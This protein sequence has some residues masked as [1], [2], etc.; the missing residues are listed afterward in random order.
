MFTKIKQRIERNLIDEI[1]NLS[2][3]DLEKVGTHMLSV[4]ENIEMLNHGIN[5]E[6]RPC[7]YT[8]DS[9][10]QD[11]SIVGEYSVERDYFTDFSEDEEGG[12]YKKIHKDIM[13][14]L[15]HGGENLQKIYLI[16]SQEEIPSFR[17]KFNKTKDFIENSDTVNIID[18]RLMAQEIYK[19]TIDSADNMSFYKGYFP[20]FIQ[21]CENYEYYGKIPAPCDN[22]CRD[23]A[24]L[25][26][27]D[28]HF[29]KKHSLCLLYGVSGSGK[30]QSVIEYVHYKSSDFQNYI[31]IAG[32]DWPVETS[33]SSIKRTRGGVPVNSPRKCPH[34]RKLRFEF[35]LKF[36][37]NFIISC[38]SSF[39]WYN[40]VMYAYK[41]TVNRG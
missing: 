34:P 20:N 37:K 40:T 29:Q 8:V 14:A 15:S 22:F 11:A 5:K 30:T 3:T 23:M 31:W 4:L 6:G 38:T 16:T 7:G 41:K 18:A 26:K 21:E 28:R 33:L 12:C 32:D 27:L 17:K 36:L 39:L 35:T 19:Q 13:H 10:S 9:F 25:D 1:K 24:V 2:A